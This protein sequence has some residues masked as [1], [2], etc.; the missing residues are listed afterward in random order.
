MIA[1]RERA[2]PGK[3]VAAGAPAQRQRGELKPEPTRSTTR[4]IIAYLLI[5]FGLA[6]TV[7]ITL[8]A[9]GIPA[10][11]PLFLIG[12]FAPALATVVVR[13]WVTREGFGDAGLLPNLRRS[14]PYYLVAWL[15]PLPVFGAALLIA[16]LAGFPILEN[17]SPNI[18]PAAMTALA[19]TF[20]LWGEEF[21][22]RGYLQIRLY[23]DRPLLA[24]LAT[25]AIWGVWHYPGVVTGLA[26][27]HHGLLGLLLYPFYAILFS[28]IL[29]WL[30]LR[31]GSAWAPSLAHAAN[32]FL[33]AVGLSGA[34]FSY[35]PGNGDLVLSP[36]GLCFL[37]PM[38]ALCVWI[39]LSGRLRPA[40][41]SASP[42]DPQRTRE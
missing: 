5:A 35:E 20:L 22:W 28:I 9:L 12:V 6:W 42:A 2:Q 8:G 19:A 26:P 39:V 38:L 4:G 13:R 17:V 32:N 33:L 10:S 11:N 3:G 29:G 23:A 21:G 34:L 36:Q 27:N 37:I 7:W 18:L 24:A 30:Q 14:W 31:T 1:Q 16:P 15:W 25:G 41:A 40:K